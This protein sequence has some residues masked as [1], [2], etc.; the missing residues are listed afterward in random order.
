[1]GNAFRLH[2]LF[3]F[4]NDGMGVMAD[5]TKIGWTEATWNIITGCSIVS[6]GCV[7]CY[8][9]GLAGTR[10]KNHPS[11]KG[12][13]NPSK[14]GPVWNGQVR[15][16]EQWIDQPMRWK[17]PRHIF[18]AAHGDLFH[19]HVHDDWI[20][21]IF[22]IMARCPQHTFQILTKRPERMLNFIKGPGRLWT[23]PGHDGRV[24][25]I[26]P[27]PLPN[28]WLGVSAENQ[29]YADERIPFLL[30]TPA[31]R[32]FVSL[33]PQIEHIHLGYIGW[34]DLSKKACARNGI[35][36]LLGMDYRNERHG[37]EMPRLDWVIQGCESGRN[38]RDFNFDWARS[39]RDQCEAAGIPYF[40]KQMP[41]D[42][43]YKIVTEP[44]LDGV[45]HLGMIK[46][47]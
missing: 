22:G 26:D 12:L 19:E 2:R 43:K 8:A 34:P 21:T 15:F 10:L 11:R 36:A 28:V 9:M 40:L 25:F 14:S 37:A 6:P 47:D 17:K 31:A 27:W 3:N 38:R 4:G 20:A 33:E 18:V 30:D 32:H 29:K 5:K 41:I 24:T 23:M 44:K 42:G 46:N 7:N 16:N 13:T 1:M 35:N 39:M 45:R